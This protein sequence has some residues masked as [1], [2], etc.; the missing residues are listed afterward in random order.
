MILHRVAG[1][2]GSTGRHIRTFEVLAVLGLSFSRS[3][4]RRAEQRKLPGFDTEPGTLR[5]SARL[6]KSVYSSAL[7]QPPICVLPPIEY[8]L[9][10]RL[11]QLLTSGVFSVP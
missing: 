5:C 9:R 4:L 8:V 2:G 1:I 10:N 11:Q 3:R 6:G 7:S